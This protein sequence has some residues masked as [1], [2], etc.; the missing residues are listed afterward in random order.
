MNLTGL[1]A[2]IVSFDWFKNHSTSTSTTVSPST[3]DNN[4]LTVEVNDGN[5]W[6]AI[7][8]DN[9]NLN[10][11][12]TV[13]V[14][15]AASYIGATIQVR[16]TVDKNVS[17]NGY[18]YDDVLLDNVEIKQNPNLATSEAAVK[19]NKLKVYPNPF[20][21]TLTISDVSKVQSVSIL[22]V[23]G[24]LVKTIENPS[25]VLQLRDLKEGMYLVVLNMKDG[26]KQTVKAIKR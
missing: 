23:A 12:R 18:F 21:D 3:Y 7:F 5:G 2:P 19:D 6:V 10:Q 9:T 15:L 16:F 4:K 11:W 24:R 14:P 20:I 22:D 1:T 17:G 25:S 26:S 13:A 8:S